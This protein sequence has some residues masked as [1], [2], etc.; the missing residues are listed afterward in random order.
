[1][2]VTHASQAIF[3]LILQADDSGNGSWNA[4]ERVLSELCVGGHGAQDRV[5]LNTAHAERID[6]ANQQER[7]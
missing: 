7:P 6:R 4:G 3:Q 1:M 5:A 2:R